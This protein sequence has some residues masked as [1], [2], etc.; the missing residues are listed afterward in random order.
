MRELRD[1]AVA[2]SH[3]SIIWNWSKTVF[4]YLKTVKENARKWLKNTLKNN[5]NR[6]KRV[7][8]TVFGK[9]LSTKNNSNVIFRRQSYVPIFDWQRVELS[10]FYPK[11]LLPVSCIWWC[12]FFKVFINQLKRILRNSS[13]VDVGRDFER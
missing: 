11:Q 4:N 10:Y 12:L 6:C 8:T 7:S 3:P 5:M 2:I 9:N 1:S 13:D